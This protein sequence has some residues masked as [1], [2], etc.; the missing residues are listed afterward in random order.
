MFKKI[1]RF[2]VNIFFKKPLKTLWRLISGFFGIVESIVGFIDAILDAIIRF[3]CPI[4]HTK[5]RPD[6]QEFD[7]YI[8]NKVH[9]QV[10]KVA[11]VLNAIEKFFISL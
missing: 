6:G 1:G 8:A 9:R 7:D 4:L 5:K 2:F 10:H 3:I 11:Q